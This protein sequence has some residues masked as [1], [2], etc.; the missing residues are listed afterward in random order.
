[1][2]CDM[3][4]ARDSA[5]TA[6]HTLLGVNLFDADRQR[7]HLHSHL[8][9]SH[10]HDAV[11]HLSQLNIPQARQTAAVL[12]VQIEGAWGFQFGCN[13]QRVA[14]GVAC[15]CSRLPQSGT[16]LSG[17]ELVRLALE[18]GHSARHA[19][20]VLTDLITRYGQRDADVPASHVVFLIADPHEACVLEVAGC[21]WALLECGETRAVADVGLIRQDWKRLS[22]GLAEQA[23]MNG[24]WNDDGTKLD[25]AGSMG[26]NDAAHAWGLKRW[27]KATLAL[28]QRQGGLD[29]YELRRLLAEQWDVCVRRHE[30]APRGLRQLGSVV[31][32]LDAPGAPLI[33]FAPRPAE[34]QLFIPLVVGM[35]LPAMY[36]VAASESIGLQPARLPSLQGQFDLEA[37]EYLVEAHEL[38][39]RGESAARA[40][41]AQAMMLRHAEQCEG[42][43][44][45]SLDSPEAARRRPSHAEEEATP[46]AFG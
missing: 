18:R 39:L 12:G 28:A 29:A 13:H 44:G 31:A 34:A 3:V 16:G 46:F 6:R 1:M 32:R 43:S 24:W 19:V 36:R 15:W 26:V 17:A 25:F 21:Y 5:T 23:I 8:A 40:R 11:V 38:E 33:W 2:G 10:P 14:V 30:L 9:E 42:I 20:E 35:E 4:L 22:H 7:V 27:S 41:L 37:E 45:R